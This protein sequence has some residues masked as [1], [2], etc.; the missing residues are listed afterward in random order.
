MLYF[1]WCSKAN[2]SVNLLETKQYFQNQ[3]D[4]KHQ[5]IAKKIV[6]VATGIFFAKQIVIPF[7]H[8]EE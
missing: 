2:F 6:L 4:E 8:Q 3:L 5:K 1:H 7:S